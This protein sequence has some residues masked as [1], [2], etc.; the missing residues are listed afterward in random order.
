MHLIS[1]IATAVLI[2]VHVPLAFVRRRQVFRKIPA[3]ASGWRRF[4]TATVT[5]TGTTAGALI[6]A[7]IAWPNPAVEFPPP[8]GYGLPSFTQQYDEYR[9]NPFAPTYART[10]SGMLV[11]PDVLS[12]S[13]SCGT[14][15]MVRT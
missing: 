8:E 6:A 15:G 13:N 14:S 4:I 3:L 11:D 9:G 10:E 2:V 5:L 1:G 12:G 7:S